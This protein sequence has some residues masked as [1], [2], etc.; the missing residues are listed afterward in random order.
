MTHEQ[1]EED[2]LVEQACRLVRAY[3]RCHPNAADTSQGIALWWLGDAGPALQGPVLDAALQCLADAGVLGCT[4]LPSSQ[5]LWF[6]A[7][8]PG[9]DAPGA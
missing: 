9:R 1:P 6:A 8:A 5:R 2:A 4:V 3:L 7:R